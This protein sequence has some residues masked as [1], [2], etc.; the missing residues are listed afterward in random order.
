MNLYL[1]LLLNI[2]LNFKIFLFKLL[3]CV[4]RFLLFLFV[5]GDEIFR[6]CDRHSVRGRIWDVFFIF[7]FLDCSS[8]FCFLL[9]EFHCNFSITYKNT[10]ISSLLLL[11]FDYVVIA[12]RDYQSSFHSLFRARITS[13]ACQK[14][15]VTSTASKP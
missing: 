9:I 8:P 2:S 4:D 6:A 15:T 11:H 14:L 12:Y 1:L 5:E 13:F 3:F 10:I 7:R